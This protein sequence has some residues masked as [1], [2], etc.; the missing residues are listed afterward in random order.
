MQ[1][2]AN[3]SGKI[4]SVFG[5]AM[6]NVI[7]VDSLRSLPAGAEYGFALVFFY[8]LAALMFFIPTALVTAEL[9]TAWPNTGGVYVWVRT[10]FGK[11]AGL[12]AIWL[13]WIYNVVWYP[14]ILTFI[15]STLAYFINPALANNKIYILVVVLSIWWLATGINCLGMKVSS[16]VSTWGAIVGTI[17]PMAAITILGIVW[18]SSGKSSQVTFSVKALLPNITNINNLAFLSTLI[19]GLMGLEM[20]AVHAGDVKNPKRD[21]P[22]ALLWS[23]LLIITT[24][25]LASLAIA[26]VVPNAKLSVLTGLTDAYA[27]F[28]QSYHLLFALPIVVALIVMGSFAGVSAWVIGPTRGLMVAL[29]ENGV[30]SRWLKL[31]KNQMPSGLLILQGIIVTLLT[32]VFVLEPTVNAAYWLLSAMTSQLAVLFYLFL[33]AAAIYLRYQNADTERAFRIPGGKP[34]MWIVAGLGIVSCLITF[35]LGFL[36]PTGVQIGKLWHFELTLILGTVVFCL[37]PLGI[38]L[39]KMKKCPLNYCSDHA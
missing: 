20:S 36:P 29:Q 28:F 32:S 2:E 4:L 13:Q 15:A 3:K 7:A 8:I 9:A 27:A 24:L 5:L 30:Q 38:Y 16:R 6:I 23:S 12:L 10:A 22:R 31:N 25:I 33:F 21:Y 18:L 11:G 34:G 37:L 39:F 17:I 26:V 19:F 1:I 35:L 14:T